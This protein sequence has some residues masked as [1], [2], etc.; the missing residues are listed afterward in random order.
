MPCM[1]QPFYISNHKE[2]LT[3]WLTSFQWQTMHGS[4]NGLHGSYTIRTYHLQTH[5]ILCEEQHGFQTGKSC[6]LQLIVTTNEFVNCMNGN[7]QIGAI[8]FDFSKAF[9]KVPHQRLLNKLSHYG[10]GGSTLVWIQS[11]L[12]IDIKM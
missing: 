11:Y 7:K 6:D 9:D 10:I 8:F 1:S 4:K 5:G 3:S 2:Q 12:T